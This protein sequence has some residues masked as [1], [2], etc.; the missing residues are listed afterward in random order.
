MLLTPKKLESPGSLEVW[1]DEMGGW[2][3]LVVTGGLGRGMGF[4]PVGINKHTQ[5][6]K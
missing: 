2:D 6:N 1:W 3:I 4:G 5:T